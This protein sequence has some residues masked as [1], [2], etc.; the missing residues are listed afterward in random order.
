MVRSAAVNIFHSVLE[1]R[2]GVGP[3][4][5]LHSHILGVE[6]LGTA[7]QLQY[8]GPHLR[9]SRIFP[10]SFRILCRGRRMAQ[11]RITS[12]SACRCRCARIPL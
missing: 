12:F 3:Y 10:L 9:Y 4:V 7:V 2:G 6:N 1:G 5:G 8:V 11:L